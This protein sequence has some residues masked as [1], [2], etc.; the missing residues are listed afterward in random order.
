MNEESHW[1]KIASEY[2]TEI[3]D[4][5]K[6]DRKKILPR[7]FRK[8]TNRNHSAID[9]G[10]GTGKAFP[11][12][13]PLFKHLTAVDISSECL[14]IAKQR[15]Y[16]NISF[17]QL[18]LSKSK[19]NLPKVDFAFCCNVIMLPEIEKN[20]VMIKNIQRSLRPGGTALLVL[21]SLDSIIY[22]SWRLIDWY[23]QEGVTVEKIPASELAYFK[24]NKRDILRG[25]VH[26][27][28]RQTKHF[29]EPELNVL[30]TRAGLQITA[31]K[32]VE[33]DWDTEFSAP[34]KWMHEPY[35]WDWLVE[36]R[37]DK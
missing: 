11:Y 17:K 8:H 1:D 19:L 21:P 9:F 28:G 13:S 26:I 33:Y 12:L 34:P 6:S 37:N 30:F 27:D 3:F 18:D 29:S 31:L 4:V 7:Y 5:F 2:N 35:P 25:V 36:C 15:P 14:A 32:K 16:S 24:G 20:E 10:C 22:S 23:R